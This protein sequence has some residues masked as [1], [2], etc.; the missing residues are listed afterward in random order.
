MTTSPSPRSR[1]KQWAKPGGPARPA[2]HLIGAYGLVALA[3]LL[4]LVFSLALPRTFPTLDN[5]SVDPVQPVDPGDPRARRDGPHRHRQVRPV[6]RLR[7]RPGARHGDAARRQPAAGRGR[8]PA[9]PCSSAGQSSGLSTASSSSSPRSTPS[10]PPSAPAAS[11]TPSPAGSPTAAGSSRPRRAC[12]RVHR[13]STTRSSSACRSPRSTSSPSPSCSGCCWSGC[14]SAGYLYVI[15]SNPRAAD[16]VGIPTRR[17]VDLRLR[18]VRDWSSASPAYCSPPSSRSATRA[19][20][21]TICCRPSSAP[22][23]APPRSNPVGPTPSGPSSPSPCWPSA[24]PASGSSAPSS[25]SIPLFNGGTLLLAVGLAG[26]SARRRLRSRPRPQ[27]PPD[28]RT[29]RPDRG[30]PTSRAATG[31]RPGQRSMTSSQPQARQRPRSHVAAV[32]AAARRRQLANAADSTGPA[33]ARLPR[34]PSPGQERPSSRPSE[35]DAPWNGPTSGPRGGIGQEPS[36]TSRRRMTNPGVAGVAEGVEE[37]AKAIGWN[38]RVID[39]QGT[40]AGI[41][42]AFSQAIALQARPASSSAA[43]T[44]SRPRSRS[45]RPTRRASR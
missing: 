1:L 25:G 31:P 12:R 22:C 3:A 19:S 40:P 26:Y 20:A 36:S 44:P 41:Q 24:W 34:K 43:S 35:A 21:S 33:I 6:H 11:C 2:A 13:P 10:S 27:H 28:R 38:V 39:G 23:S 9:S 37:A 17:Y 4:V 30:R 16:L 15:G 14:R 5:L 7:P 8:L 45:R 32:L 29:S 18:R 42:A